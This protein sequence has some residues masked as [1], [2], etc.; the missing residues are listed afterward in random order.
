MSMVNQSI[1]MGYRVWRCAISQ[2][3]KSSVDSRFIDART[4]HIVEVAARD[5]TG[6]NPVFGVSW[7]GG[8]GRIP[9]LRRRETGGQSVA[10]SG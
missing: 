6:G 10:V 2:S 8:P 7:T 5:D 9:R 3:A 4:Y 1:Y